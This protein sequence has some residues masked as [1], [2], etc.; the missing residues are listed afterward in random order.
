[1]S[2]RAPCRI[3]WPGTAVLCLLASTVIS[4][5]SESSPAQ[6]EDAGTGDAVPTIDFEPEGEGGPGM[7]WLRL[8]EADP[9]AGT[10][11]LEVVGDGL[12]SVYGVA[13]RLLFDTGVCALESAAPGGAL[14]GGA[15]VVIAAGAGNG[16]GGVFGVSRSGD[17]S[18]GADLA[19]DAVVGTLSFRIV[20]PGSTEIRFKE[21]RSRAMSPSLE[22]VEV[23][24]WLG[25]TLTAE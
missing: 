6:L 9:A 15:A 13:G 8:A 12:A 24:D 5:C 10:F 7:I 16:E 4:A 22:K 23:A 1:M 19:A 2:D 20:Q 11:S 18:A 21:N 3:I 17:F 25:G 14:E